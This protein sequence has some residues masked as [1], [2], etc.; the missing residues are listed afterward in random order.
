MEKSNKEIKLYA[1]P[2]E[3]SEDCLEFL[4]SGEYQEFSDF[5]KTHCAKCDECIYLDIPYNEGG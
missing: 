2:C 5:C 3:N 1:Y 4:E